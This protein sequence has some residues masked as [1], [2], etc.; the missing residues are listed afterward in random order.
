MIILGLDT[1]AKNCTVSLVDSARV[2]ALQSEPIGRGHAERLAPMVLETLHIAGLSVFDIDKITVCTGPGSFTGLRVALA[3]A[4]GLA[5]PRKIPI[6]GVNALT[7][8][9]AEMDPEQSLKIVSVSDVRRGQLCW[10]AFDKGRCIQPPITQE[11]D[12]ARAEIAKLS[13]DKLI[14]DKPV[15]GAVLAWL[16]AG[17]T[18]D[19]A[20]ALPLY[21]RPPDAKL[22]GGVTPP[23]TDV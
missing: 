10:S 8:W 5:L 4:K 21:S 11:I 2:L 9:A 18:P 19:L 6:I 12:R 13:A 20:P 7:V 15:N 3:F 22:P 16:G 23:Q 1:T 17:L 14:E